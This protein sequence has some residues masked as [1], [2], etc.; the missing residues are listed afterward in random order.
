MALTLDRKSF[1]DIISEGQGIIGGAM[2]P[3]PAGVW[4]MPPEMLKTAARLRPRC[5]GE[6]RAK[7]RAIMREARLWARQA[8]ED[9]GQHA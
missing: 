2:Q 8:A 7:A 1:I 6:P 9:Q 3:P 4:G 5:R